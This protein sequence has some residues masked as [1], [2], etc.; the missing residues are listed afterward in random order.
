MAQRIF[1]SYRSTDRE[2]VRRLADDLKRLGHTV[3]FD[4]ELTSTGGQDW[5]DNILAQIRGCDLF[6][7]AL[8]DDSLASIPCQREYYYAAQLQKR[9]LPVVIR[10]SNLDNLPYELK[11]IQYVSYEEGSREQVIA[12][13]GSLANLPA[14]VPLPDP[15]PKPPAIPLSEEDK[16]LNDIEKLLLDDSL[17]E[18]QQARILLYFQQL[19]DSN[20]Y[21]TDTKFK[22]TV[23][24][25]LRRFL[26]RDDLF[27]GVM[28]R[29]EALQRAVTQPS[30]P[31]KTPAQ[32]PG[33]MGQSRRTP[34]TNDSSKRS[35]DAPPETTQQKRSVLPLTAGIAVALVIVA[36]VII[37]VISNSGH[38]GPAAAAQM[39]N[40]PSVQPPTNT[41]GSPTAT[42]VPLTNTSV[43]PST[44]TI[45]RPTNT[46]APALTPTAIPVGAVLTPTIYAQQTIKDV[47]FVWVPA[48]CFMMGSDPSKDTNAQSYE[49]PQHKVCITH[50]FWIGEF[51][52][53]NAQFDAYVKATGATHQVTSDCS[54]ASNAPDQPV[55]CVSWDDAVAYAKWLGGR[56]PTEAE[57]EYAARGPASP[58]YPWGNTFDQTKANTYENGLGKTTSVGKYPAGVSWVS[59]QDMAG[60]VWQWTA[61]W[62]DANYYQ[63]SPMNDPTGPTSGQYRVVRGGSWY[64]NQYC[65]RAADRNHSSPGNRDYDVGFRVVL[66]VPS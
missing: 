50:G 66:S 21:Q 32:K 42:S 58:I 55:V 27:S 60:N 46:S 57:W 63:N 14:P 39:T 53:T 4:P 7:F 38:G 26:D 23:D 8:S 40:T 33:R 30:A 45:V 62:Y 24:R 52:I 61:D 44:P 15:L 37:L 49:Q 25:L 41:P 19:T 56:L 9:I 28:R 6:V 20:K 36:A 43:P 13:A 64:L 31:V 10:S 11:A 22:A 17:N 18:D 12:L 54:Q 65:A 48:G 3:W 16:K 29:T 34:A 51:D 59:A 1:I 47:A 5:W 35:A 2:L